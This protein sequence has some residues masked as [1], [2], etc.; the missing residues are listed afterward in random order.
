MKA[1]WWTCGCGRKNVS[2][3]I[4]VP[5]CAACGKDARFSIDPP[6]GQNGFDFGGAGQG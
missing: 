5:K 1:R 3:G 2:R 6:K 4:G